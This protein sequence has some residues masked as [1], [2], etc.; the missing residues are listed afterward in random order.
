M[1]ALRYPLGE[2]HLRR[3]LTEFAAHYHRERNHQGLNNDLIDGVGDE[4]SSVSARRVS[5]S[6]RS[7]L[8]LPCGVAPFRRG[9]P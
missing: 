8:L 4:P 6:W 3:A 2:R 1:P 5:A 7:Q 9:S